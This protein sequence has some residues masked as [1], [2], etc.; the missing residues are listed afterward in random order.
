MTGALATV[1]GATG[2][3]PGADAE[4]TGVGTFGAAV[5]GSAVVVI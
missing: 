3:G 4:P 1:S 2:D 5:R